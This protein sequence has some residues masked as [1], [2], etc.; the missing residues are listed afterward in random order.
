MALG[1]ANKLLR[2]IILAENRAWVQSI[3]VDRSFSVPLI[4]S[5]TQVINSRADEYLREGRIR[6]ARGLRF[7]IAEAGRADQDCRYS[8]ATEHPSEVSGIDSCRS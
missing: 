7:G 5:G 1:K 8:Q 3:P 2:T 6:V 4:S